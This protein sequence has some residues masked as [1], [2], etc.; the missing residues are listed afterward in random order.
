MNNTITA[1]LTKGRSYS[2][3]GKKYVSGMNYNVENTDELNV[4]VR[5]GQFTISDPKPQAI[6]QRIDDDDEDE[7]TEDQEEEDSESEPTK[8][9]I[10][11]ISHYRKKSKK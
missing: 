10:K 4:I 2:V 6:K 11:K 5:S 8:K 7:E 3:Q 1:R 9:W